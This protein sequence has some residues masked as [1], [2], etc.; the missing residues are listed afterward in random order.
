MSVGDAGA[1]GAAGAPGLVAGDDEG[2]TI[3]AVDLVGDWPQA[4]TTTIAAATTSAVLTCIM[5]P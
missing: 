3:A 2:E 1:V 5:T 4:A